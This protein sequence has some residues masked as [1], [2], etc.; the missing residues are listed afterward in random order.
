MDRRDLGVQ[1]AINSYNQA[2]RYGFSPRTLERLKSYI[3]YM[4]SIGR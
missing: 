2:R 3:S 4:R 1:E